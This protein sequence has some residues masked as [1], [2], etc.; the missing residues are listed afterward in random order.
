M[1]RGCRGCALQARVLREA[2]AAVHAVAAAPMGA[3]G[4]AA[5]PSVPHAVLRGPALAGMD[6]AAGR[7]RLGLPGD[8][9]R[10]SLSMGLAAHVAEY[11]AGLGDSL[12]C[13]ADLRRVAGRPACPTLGP[14]PCRIN[15]LGHPSGRVLSMLGAG[16]CAAAGCCT[17]W[18]V[19]EV[20]THAA[21]ATPGGRE[22][23]ADLDAPARAW[24][25]ERIHAMCD[26]R[27]AGA[28]RG[29][30]ADSCLL[31]RVAAFQVPPPALAGRPGVRCCK[32]PLGL[33]QQEADVQC[34]CSV[35]GRLKRGRGSSR[36]AACEDRYVLLWRPVLS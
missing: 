11:F 23:V 22:Y 31:R 36:H 7:L 32:V 19:P 21:E 17:P 34:M 9:S 5:A 12:S 8:G 15:G 3:A 24:L 13:A 1:S 4:G 16:T 35:R 2:E 26:E 10:A 30:H 29:R 28:A 18:C 20:C 33:P 27:E 6:L 14:S 25:S